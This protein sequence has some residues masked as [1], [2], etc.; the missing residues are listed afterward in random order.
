LDLSAIN[1]SDAFAAKRKCRSRISKQAPFKI[2][3]KDMS[4][5]VSQKDIAFSLAGGTAKD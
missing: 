4:V 3:V 1:E 2:P 5:I